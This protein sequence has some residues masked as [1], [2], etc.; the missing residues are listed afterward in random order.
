[1]ASKK[2]LFGTNGIRGIVN[3]QLTNEFVTKVARSI[4]TYVGEG[5]KVIIGQDTR[6][7][8]EMIK[9]NVISV[10]LSSGINVYDAGILP[11][12]SLQLAS[13]K[14][15]LFGI[16]VT[17]SHNPPE[18]NGIKC[19]D[20]DGTELDES[21]EDKIEDIFFK[22]EYRSTDWRKMGKYQ[23]I[24]GLNNDYVERVLSLVDSSSIKNSGLKVLLDC[25]NGPSFLTS[26]EIL[27]RLNVKFSTI[28]CNPDGFFS[29]H[30]P[31][32]KEENLQDL[33]KFTSGNYDL[34]IAHD[35]D[36]DRVVFV[37]ELGNF[38]PGDKILA[39]ITKDIVQKR[40]GTIVLP[41][42]ASQAIEE[43]AN[44]HGSKV[45]YTKVGAPI[46]ARKM[47]E[48]NAIFGGE[49]NGGL[50]FPEMQYCRDGG[51]GMAKMIEILSKEG[52][53]FSEILKDLPEYFV[54]KG[55]IDVEKEKIRKV[56]DIVKTQV[57]GDRVVDIDGIKIYEGSSW[58][59]I[60]PSGTEPIIRIYAESNSRKDVESIFLKYKSM[61]ESISK[62][63]Q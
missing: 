48:V 32:P 42:S 34:G 4:A 47:I 31:E 54:K 44:R 26:V 27:R 20:R 24:E 9:M 13:K 22:N 11:T 29:S 58:V 5:S 33:M 61:V 28:N 7:S 40:S 25:S 38:I 52:K 14:S 30:N 43:I 23:R 63:M 3:V 6:V 36:A 59:L 18:Y 35:G 21:E 19:I 15:G 53:R 8:G 45:V 56:M 62:E 12:P 41:V 46:I 39:L 50:I 16:M 57:H 51:M 55:S 10:L 17:A 2:G 1:M 60:R 37:D 49:D